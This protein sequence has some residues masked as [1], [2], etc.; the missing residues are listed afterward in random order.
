[1]QFVLGLIVGLGIG[2]VIMLFRSEPSELGTLRIVTPASDPDEN[3]Y[4]F[5]ELNKGI[6][7]I[8]QY[9]QGLFRISVE[10]YGTRK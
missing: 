5:M 9:E 7:N 2:I 3:P 10:K 8:S 6:G 1:M 4:M